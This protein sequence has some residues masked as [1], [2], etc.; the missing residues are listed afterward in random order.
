MRRTILRQGFVILLLGLLAGFGVVAGGPHARAW[1]ATHLTLMLTAVLVTLVGLVWDELALSPRQRKILRF[2]VVFDGYFGAI[3]GVF[4]TV[5][6]IPGPVSGHGATPS[7]WPAT[8]FLSLFIPVLTVL[9]FVFTGLVLYG[10]RGLGDMSHRAS[11]R[12]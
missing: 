1:L 4:A 12:D 10:L 7:G 3:A 9:P 11:A 6:E 2:A 5:F 8:L